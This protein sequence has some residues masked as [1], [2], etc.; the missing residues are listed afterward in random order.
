MWTVSVPCTADPFE[1]AL[2]WEWLHVLPIN[3]SCMSCL[4]PGAGTAGNRSV[5]WAH[6]HS[7]GG[8]ALG[9]L[10]SGSVLPA[11]TAL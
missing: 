8:T 11:V 7:S 5:S 4:L 9:S 1:F 6:L 3:G 2:V 10:V